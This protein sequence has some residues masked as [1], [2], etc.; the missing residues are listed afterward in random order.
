MIKIKD[1]ENYLFKL[2]NLNYNL[3]INPENIKIYN[4]KI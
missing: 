3:N 2:N 1:L 4:K